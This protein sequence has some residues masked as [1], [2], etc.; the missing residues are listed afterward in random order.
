MKNDNS[1]LMS[2][3]FYFIFKPEASIGHQHHCHIPAQSSFKFSSIKCVD[4]TSFLN[5]SFCFFFFS[6]SAPLFPR[7]P[8]AGGLHGGG[9]SGVPH[10]RA[11]LLPG[12]AQRRD[13]YQRGVVPA[14][15]GLRHVSFPK[16]KSKQINLTLPTVGDFLLSQWS[17]SS[18][19]VWLS[20][21]RL[22]KLNSYRLWGRHLAWNWHSNLL[23]R[24]IL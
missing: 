4:L 22:W 24:V 2:L 11:V 7:V 10:Q 3:F 1:F 5:M 17:S 15:P 23:C 20:H 14:R 9:H 6:P 19:R 16:A 8:V 21:V 12:W 18:E 13:E